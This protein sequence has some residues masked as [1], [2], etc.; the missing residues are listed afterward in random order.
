MASLLPDVFFA[1]QTTRLSSLNVSR[2][3]SK[4]QILEISNRKLHKKTTFSTERREER[5]LREEQEQT[6]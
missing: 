3:K 1:S 5:R 2:A 6:L 4:N